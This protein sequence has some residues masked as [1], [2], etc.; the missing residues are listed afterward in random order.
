MPIVS[1][2]VINMERPPTEKQPWQKQKSSTSYA[3]RVL[4]AVV[5]LLFVLSGAAL[6]IWETDDAPLLGGT[7]IGTIGIYLAAGLT[8]G[9]L[10]VGVAAMLRLLREMHASLVRMEQFQYERHDSSSEVTIAD[11]STQAMP[12]AVRESDTIDSPHPMDG[13][14][15]D[16]IRLL[17]DI[18][19]NSLL[20]EAQ[21][22]KKK[23]HVAEE[24]LHDA[25]V[26]LRTLVTRR[27]FVQAR[28]IAQ[29]TQRKYPDD[30]RAAAL[31]EQVEEAR[32]RQESDDVIAI[33]KQVNDLISI[34]AWPRARE[35]ASQLQERHPDSVEARQLL[36]RIEREYKILQD[37]Q[38]RRMYAEVQ[39]FVTRRRWEEALATARTFIERFPGCDESEAMQLEIPTL[40][41]NAEIDVRQKLEAKIMNLAKTGRYIEAVELAKKVIEKY[42]DSPQ[43]GALRTQIGRLEEL[44]H[45]PQAPPA[46][47]KKD[48]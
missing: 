32:Q 39:R 11:R 23:L 17:Q 34:S 38:R 4:G 28:E 8:C 15:Q 18:R 9:G 45:D 42:P 6:L 24:E 10:L 29:K 7:V 2:P 37:E 26:F 30:E 14:W 43:A 12:A 46:R 44:A 33:S 20:S 3:L 36:L 22:E 5:V 27:D 21:R 13:S 48:D 16:M 47:I 1:A 35:V 19:D 25:K 40:K 41:T 31:V